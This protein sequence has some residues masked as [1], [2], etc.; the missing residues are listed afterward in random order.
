MRYFAKGYYRV[1]AGGNDIKR[2]WNMCA[3]H[4]IDIWNLSAQKENY[5]F[6]LKKQDYEKFKELQE[7]TDVFVERKKE[8]GFPRFVAKVRRHWS[9]FGGIAVAFALVIALSQFV[10]SI[11]IAGNSGYGK[12]E[13]QRF[14]KEQQVEHGM[15]KQQVNCFALAESLREAFP[16]ITWVTAK[17]S[18]VKLIIQLKE[19]ILPEEKTEEENNEESQTAGA[20]VPSNLIAEKDGVIVRMITRTGTP[21]M[22]V[23]Q[24]CKKGDVLVEGT[25]PIYN[26]SQEIVRYEYAA[27]DAEV[28]IRTVY[29]YYDE[30]ERK[31][32]KRQYLETKKLPFLQVGPYRM[33]DAYHGQ[34][35]ASEDKLRQY[36]QVHLTSTFF[37]PIYYGVTNSICYETKDANYSEQEAEAI[38]NKHFSV[39]QNN[40]E[41]KGVQIYENNVRIR[42]SDVKCVMKGTVLVIEKTGKV[43]EIPQEE[44]IQKEEIQEE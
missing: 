37:L 42:I 35:S 36:R 16:N 26:D 17:I 38:A 20:R 39:F 5:Q 31:Y 8:Y 2:L 3:F 15:P 44:Q 34:V 13:I 43:K 18:G 27:A 19:N 10:W 21:Q 12:E 28:E 7:K 29:Q 40:L 22:A 33:G 30:F 6:S 14:L 25:V 11:C 23:G 1:Q 24:T 9:F 32:I 41:K 4:G